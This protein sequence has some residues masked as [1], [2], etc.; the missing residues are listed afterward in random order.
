MT[1]NKQEYMDMLKSM[2]NLMVKGLSNNRVREQR[3]YQRRH[4]Q[5]K[6]YHKLKEID[7]D[8]KEQRLALWLPLKL[9]QKL[10]MM[11]H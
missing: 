10:D 9:E 2:F 1:L 4:G 5:E 11:M 3:R 6:S 7:F 8:E